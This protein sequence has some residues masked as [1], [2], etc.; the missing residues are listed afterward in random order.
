MENTLAQA[1]I[2]HAMNTAAGPLRLDL[3][4]PMIATR[5]IGRAVA[6]ALLRLDFT[7]RQTR[8][9]LGQRDLTMT[10]AARIIGQ[11]IGKP[12]LAYV[13][14]SDDQF[15]GAL[16][17]AGISAEMANLILEMTTA[18]NSGHMRALEARSAMN[19]TPT[20]FETFVAEELVPVY[21]GKMAHA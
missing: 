18:M 2:I 4:V 11:A 7:G 19:T 8:E 10:E 21:E 5:D 16:T 14:I 17:Q 6:D 1:N 9:L 12:E 3:K 20:S 13:R 15:R